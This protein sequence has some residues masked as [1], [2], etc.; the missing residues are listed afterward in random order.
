M[1]NNAYA[2]ELPEPDMRKINNLGYIPPD[3]HIFI[4]LLQPQGPKGRAGKKNTTDKIK[5]IH[6]YSVCWD[7][8]ITEPSDPITKHTESIVIKYLDNRSCL[9][10]ILPFSTSLIRGLFLF[11]CK[12]QTQ[13]SVILLFVHAALKHLPGGMDLFM[14]SLLTQK[15]NGICLILILVVFLLI[16]NSAYF[17]FLKGC[18]SIGHGIVLL[19]V[20]P[21]GW[22][23]VLPFP[24]CRFLL[25]IHGDVRVSKLYN[26]F[27]FQIFA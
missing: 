2:A 21:S 20:W 1:S 19:D 8:V 12:S 6:N 11:V 22:G 16:C 26:K 27:I 9:T 5:P 23:Y 10:S 3:K 7:K 17:L 14:G 4:K 15:K 13:H 25:G 18:G 24:C